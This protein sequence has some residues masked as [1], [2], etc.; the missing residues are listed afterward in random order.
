MAVDR[1]DAVATGVPGPLCSPASRLQGYGRGSVGNSS[2]TAQNCLKL[3]S[4]ILRHV[5]AH[6]TPVLSEHDASINVPLPT[7]DPVRLP[8]VGVRCPSCVGELQP[9][10]SSGFRCVDCGR[11]FDRGPYPGTLAFS[12]VGANFEQ[13]LDAEIAPRLVPTLDRLQPPACTERVIQSTAAELNIPIGNPV[14]EGRADLAR[15]LLAGEHAIALDIGCGFGTFATAVARSAAHVFAT[16]RSPVRVALTAA[17]ARAEDLTNVTAFETNGIGLPLGDGICDLVTIIGVLEWVGVGTSDA[18]AA[19]RSMLAEVQRVL[20]P[21]GTLLLGIEN[22]YGAH[23]FLGAR[24]D[25]TGLRFSSVIPRR[26]AD[27]YSRKARG[28]PFE[29]PTHSRAALKRLLGDAGL[30]PRV[31][32]VLPSYQQARFAFDEADARAGLDFY[33][34]HAFHATS[35]PRRMAGRA[36]QYGPADWLAA[37]LPSFWGI[38]TKDGLPPRAPGLITGSPYCDGTIKAIDWAGKQVTAT[39]RLTGA[40]LRSES[41]VDGWNARRWVDWPLRRGQRD[42]R[43]RRLL[44]EIER[45]LK[46]GMLDPTQPLQTRLATIEARDGLSLAAATI[47]VTVQE[48]CALL[49]DGVPDISP[50][51]REHGDLILNNMVIA[52]D[53]RMTL[54]DRPAEEAETVVGR[55]VTIALLDLLSVRAGSKHLDLATGLQELQVVQ[56]EEA[57]AI[58]QM[59]HTAFAGVR[60]EHMP[61]LMLMGVM[62]HCAAHGL[63]HGTAGFL[64]AVADD[65]LEHALAA[66]GFGYTSSK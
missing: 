32:V 26:L 59:L 60:N 24:E 2:P 12:K 36:L 15:V 8:I 46:R 34:R 47:D 6:A 51:Y 16:D 38:A 50:G 11:D 10:E 28:V 43:R 30:T 17:R 19:Q 29:T 56:G 48:R 65:R 41:L 4:G 54:V 62:R 40:A 64:M 58:G 1:S 20:K 27:V 25:H 14:W 21:G 45:H 23:Y 35:T 33:V 9:V 39:S 13:P 44:A 42:E 61:G 49:L 66:L 55:D 5:S 7:A 37:L 3:A 31:A 63:I 52:A 53:R 22:R 57:L 18:D